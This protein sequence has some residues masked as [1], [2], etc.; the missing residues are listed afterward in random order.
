M[1]TYQRTAQGQGFIEVLVMTMAIIP[2]ALF[3]MDAMVVVSTNVVNDTAAK[4]AARAAAN[5]SDGS[6]AKSAALKALQAFKPS[7]IIASVQLDDFQYPLS[8]EGVTVRTKMEIK[9]P[10][11]LP[12]Y[13]TLTFLARDIEPIV[14]Q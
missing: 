4:N 8:K 5:Q 14:A 1:R 9:L 3:M 6:S 12:G 7:P 10:A 13:S 11:P 2:I